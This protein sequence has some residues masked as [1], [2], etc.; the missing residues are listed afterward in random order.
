M[1]HEIISI[2]HRIESHGTF[3]LRLDDNRKPGHRIRRLFLV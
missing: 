2:R 3:V 1:D